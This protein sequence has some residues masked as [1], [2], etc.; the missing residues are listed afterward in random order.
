MGDKAL[1]LWP[2]DIIAGVASAVKGFVVV[3]VGI[4]ING[5]AVVAVGCQRRRLT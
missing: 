1:Q 5:D 2:P 4:C 3:K